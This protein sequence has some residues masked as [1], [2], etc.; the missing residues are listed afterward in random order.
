MSTNVTHPRQRRSLDGAWQFRTDPHANLAADAP[1]SWR[2]V[3]VPAPWQSHA[4]DLR[5][6]QGVAWYRRGFEVPADWSGS[7]LV[8]H[9]GAVDY[10]A[11]VYVNGRLAGEHTGGY[12]PFDLDISALVRYGAEN[13]L[14][15]RVTDPSNDRERFPETPFDEIPHGKQ[16]WYGPLSGI[17]QSVWV[18]ARPAAHVTRLKVTPDAR[19]AQVTVEVTLSTEVSGAATL[20]LDVL[21]PTGERVATTELELRGSAAS[22]T[23][24]VPSITLWELEAPALYT[25]AATLQGAGP[26]D[27]LETRFGFRTIESRDGAL[28]LNDKPL[29]LRGALDQDYY[30]GTIATPPSYEYLVHQAQLAKRMGLNCLRCHI[31]VA[32]PRYIQ[33]ADEVGILVWAELPNWNRWTP[34]GAATGVETLIGA[35]ERDWNNPSVVIWTVINESWGVDLVGNPEHRAWLKQAFD[36]VKAAAPG[37]LVVD[38]SACFPN[39]HIKTDLDDYH[40]YTAMPDERDRWSR[41]IAQF[42]GR[43]KW[44]FASGAFDERV[45]PRSERTI[46]DYDWPFGGNA[47]ADPMPEIERT[48]QEPLILSEFGN[49]GLPSLESLRAE[50]GADPWWFETGDDWGDGVVYPHGVE[51]RFE[52]QGL[53]RIFG[54]YERFS[55]ATRRAELDALRFE[56]EEMR[57]HPSIGGYIITEFTDVHWECNGL[58]DMRRNPKMPLDALADLNADT[59]LI[60]DRR[61]GAL[62]AGASQEIAVSASHWG[63]RLLEAPEL[64]WSVSAAGQQAASD[65]VITHAGSIAPRSTVALGAVRVVAPEVDRATTATLRLELWDGGRRVAATDHRIAVFPRATGAL[66]KIH[67]DGDEALE[68]ALLGLGYT[69]ASAPGAG[70]VTVARRWTDELRTHVIEGGHVLLLAEDDAGLEWSPGHSLAGVTVEPRLGTVRQGS[71]ASSFFWMR[72]DWP[73]DGVLDDAFE[74][75]LPEYVITGFAEREYPDDVLAGMFVG[76]IRK[77]AAAA[78]VRRLGRGKALVTTFRLT[79]NLGT[80]PAATHIFAHLARAAATA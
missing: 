24:P 18:E 13:E 9:F 67:V 58:L 51:Q 16:S 75:V 39:Y 26:A 32:D 17:W 38:N 74:R 66:P 71:W 27:R 29:M 35:I 42:A 43:A 8:L 12:L 78:G 55:L 76:W 2:T 64:R 10:Y 30:P 49:W 79:N 50:T 15:V 60:P 53:D 63:A 25:L 80:D 61:Q 22:A 62:F 46:E 6:Y 21:A 7:A 44:T 52:R 48:G 56:I 57:R 34:E 68:A 47:D 40:I 37:R 3:T 73:G 33:A 54:D 72:G 77:P 5:D 14:T 20:A 65:G 19:A 1:G 45:K 36:I 11:E 23:I 59:V 70:I 69:V 28:Y 4:D 41:L 31:K